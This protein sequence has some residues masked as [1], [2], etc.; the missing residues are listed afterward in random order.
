MCDDRVRDRGGSEPMRIGMIHHDA[1]SAN[2]RVAP[3]SPIEGNS[4]VNVNKRC[5][6]CSC[7]IPIRARIC[8][9]CR[10]RIPE[11]QAL[12]DIRRADGKDHTIRYYYAGA[13]LLI[14]LAFGA[15]VGVAML[16]A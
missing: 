5:P 12:R 8:R 6:S 14:P 10:Y 3:P 15:G 11:R 2:K 1:L 4:G 9:F 13:L 7:A 16:L